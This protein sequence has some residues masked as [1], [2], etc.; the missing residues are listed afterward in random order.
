[1]LFYYCHH[2]IWHSRLLSDP[3]AGFEERILLFR[4][5]TYLVNRWWVIA[6]CLLVIVA[7]WGFALL[8][9]KKTPGLVG[10]GFL[11]YC[12]FGIAEITRQMMVL[13]YTNVLREQFYTTT[14]TAIKEGLRS[15]LQAPVSLLL[16]YS[17][18][19]FLRLD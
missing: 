3:P 4:N 5:A 11:F 10:L 15:P 8:L 9:F 7:M 6:H 12:V 2:Y 14:D 18:C 16:P 19:L 13:F 1:M 17:A